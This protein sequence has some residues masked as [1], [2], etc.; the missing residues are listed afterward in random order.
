M[1]VARK[2]KNNKGLS[3]LFDDLTSHS[4][5]WPLLLLEF[6]MQHGLCLSAFRFVLSIVNTPSYLPICENE[7]DGGTFRI[8]P[9]FD[10]TVRLICIKIAPNTKFRRP[11]FKQVGW[12]K[13][14]HFS[15]TDPNGKDDLPTVLVERA[16][17]DIMDC[18]CLWE[19]YYFS[20]EYF[21]LDFPFKGW[22]RENAKLCYQLS[23]CC[24][25][26]R[27]FSRPLCQLFWGSV[28]VCF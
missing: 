1:C 5:M 9:H 20:K 28:L 19:N 27:V 12:A 2:E 13:S 18:F 6:L 14:R 26:F 23:N 15:L 8:V 16:G 17:T 4:Q 25:I 10:I 11:W 3:F 7:F 24:E 22:A 21:W